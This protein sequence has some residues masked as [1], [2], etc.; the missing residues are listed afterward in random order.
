MECNLTQNNIFK[1]H[2]LPLNIRDW[3]KIQN[4]FPQ[5][6]GAKAQCVEIKPNN[7]LGLLS[8]MP[9]KLWNLM[10]RAQY[11]NYFSCLH[12][13]D[14]HFHTIKDLTFREFTLEI[15]FPKVNT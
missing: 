11:C 9:R 15:Q 5:K 14:T 12:K 4:L 2:I 3:K 7:L 6:Q 10:T 13:T 8:I 1:L